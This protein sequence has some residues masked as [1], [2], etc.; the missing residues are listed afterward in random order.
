MLCN[1]CKGQMCYNNLLQDLVCSF[2]NKR[3]IYTYIQLFGFYSYKTTKENQYVKMHCSMFKIN[4]NFRGSWFFSETVSVNRAWVFKSRK[5][6]FFLIER[7][8]YREGEPLTWTVFENPN[9]L[10]L[11]IPLRKL[12]VLS[13]DIFLWR[14]WRRISADNLCRAGCPRNSSG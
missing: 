11:H 12:I 8:R 2:M 1:K 13:S 4:L 14:K 10:M 3:Y 5:Y 7:L 9:I 6:I